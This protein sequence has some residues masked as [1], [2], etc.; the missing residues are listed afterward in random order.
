MSRFLRPSRLLTAVVL[1]ASSFA[2]FSSSPAGAA[3]G[4]LAS[5]TGGVTVTYTGTTSNDNV[6][7]T[8]WPAGHT[9]V[10][11]DPAMQA[12]YYMTSD[13]SAPSGMQL[14]ASPA[15]LTFGSAAFTLNGFATTTI[16]AGSYTFCLQT[17]VAGPGGQAIAAQLDAVIVDPNATTTTTSTSTT[18]TSTTTTT[19][20]AGGVATTS[21]TVASGA[22]GDPVIPAFTG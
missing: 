8:V 11:N 17:N 18:S 7:L 6:L 5:V 15:T 22:S 3:T 12:T 20:A 21:T 9:C 13:G 19:T 1:V 10:L 16:A 4:S 2:L 14:A